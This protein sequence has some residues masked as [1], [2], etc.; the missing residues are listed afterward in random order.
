MSFF[1]KSYRHCYV[2]GS[3]A[4]PLRSGITV[5]EVMAAMLVAL[6]GVFGVLVLIPF[7]VQQAQIGLDQDAAG[8]LAQNAIED[9]EIMGL[10]SVDAAGQLRFRGAQITFA[11]V[12]PAN[13]VDPVAPGSVYTIPFTINA[14][15]VFHFDPIAVSQVGFPILLGSAPLATSADCFNTTMLNPDFLTGNIPIQVPDLDDLRIPVVTATTQFPFSRAVGTGAEI[16]GSREADQLFRNLDEVAYGSTNIVGVAN[17]DLLD[18]DLQPPQ[19]VYDVSASGRL[20]RSQRNGR[21][22]WSAVF[23]PEKSQRVKPFF[24]APP[25]R[26]TRYKVYTIIYKDRSVI[27]TDPESQ[28]PASLVSRTAGGPETQATAGSVAAVGGFKSSV[29][30]IPLMPGAPISEDIQRDDWVMLINRRPSAYYQFLNSAGATITGWP[31]VLAEDELPLSYDP[32]DDPTTFPPR[33][34]AEE[35]GYQTQVSFAQIRSLSL[36]PTPGGDQPVLYVEGGPF[37]FYNTSVAG[38]LYG[39]DAAGANDPTYV[40]DTYV[41]YLRNVVTVYERTINLEQNSSW[42]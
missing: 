34:A 24:T 42:N 33:F 20:L 41:I 31:T 3:Q 6:I 17:E 22:S 13:V 18:G 25:T 16:M 9:M 32:D 37:D 40:S 15:Q 2:K 27:T 12:A 8:L 4:I 36:T 11:A 19:P 35:E 10:T 29:D 7:S 26:P 14:P 21:I 5:I 1:N 39:L 28:N 30:R 38:P 23:V